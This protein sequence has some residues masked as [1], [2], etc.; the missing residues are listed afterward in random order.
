MNKVWNVI[1]DAYGAELETRVD[2]VHFGVGI[3]G[4][5][6]L[7]IIPLVTNGLAIDLGC[8]SGENLV[9]L[10][11]LGY[12]TLGRSTFLFIARTDYFELCSLT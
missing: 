11:G 4:N 1:A 2:E 12:E 5:A 10:G 6:E 9:A 8:G 3:P 7:N